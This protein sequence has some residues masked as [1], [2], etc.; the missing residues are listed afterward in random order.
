MST[1]SWLEG[2]PAP[3][4]WRALALTHG[5]RLATWTLALALGVQAAFIVTDLSGSTK[6][7]G[8]V[9]PS[10][11]PMS[12][13]SRSVNVAAI[14]NAH[15]FGFD[16]P[17]QDP[18]DPASARPSSIPLVLTGIIAASDPR[19]GLAILGPSPAAAKVY[20]VGDNVPG[21]AKLHSV[22]SD[23]VMLDRNGSLEYLL[24]PRKVQGGGLPNGP[25]P[26]VAA[27][28]TENPVVD[29][30]RKLMNDDPGLVADI[31]RP[32]PVFAQGKQR[33]YRVY[34]GRNRQAFV[35][36]G[37]R[38]GDLVTA[39]NGTPLDDPSRG[40]DVF[41]TIGSSNEAH[42]TVMRN[43]Q[44]Q[45]LTLNMAQVAQEAESLV[46]SQGQGQ[47]DAAPPQPAPPPGEPPNSFESK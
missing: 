4:K 13:R 7:P 37:L 17:K 33:G 14:T 31:M 26:S 42:V 47:G 18:S 43:G 44:Q 16:A 30:M 27:L 10:G 15:L 3:D 35:R 19:N 2:L 11:T 23:R 22:L 6:A 9:R 24:L 12:L 39:I 45:D 36:L 8:A 46:D 20:A 34:P 5:P 21:G 1:A 38:P 32:Q 28:P 41:R 29:R 25:A 40:Q